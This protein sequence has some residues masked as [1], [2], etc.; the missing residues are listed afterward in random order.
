MFSQVVFPLPFR[1]AF[2]YSIPDEL[3]DAVK[4]GVRV[5][6]PFGKR[7]LTGFVIDISKTTELKEKI[8]P[9]RD[10]IDE[11]PIFDRTALKFYEW[12]SEYYLSS[13]GEA[14][15][16]SVP[17]GTEIESKRKVVSDKNFCEMLLNQEMK[18]NSL[19]AKLLRALSQKEVYNI[20]QLQKEV[21]NKSIYSILRSLEK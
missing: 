9:I 20:S 17:Y 13:P 1:N 4:I 14:L 2:T 6:V 5:V 11:N 7:V 21:K 19:R 12:I 10:V 16:N 3:R 18:K 8:K 15:R